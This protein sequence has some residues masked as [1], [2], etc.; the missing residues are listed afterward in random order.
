MILRRLSQSLKTQN[1]TAIWIEFILL[2]V[3][4][5][6]GI[7]V[8]NWNEERSLRAQ[9]RTYLTELSDEVRSNVRQIEYRTAYT[10]ILLESGKTARNFLESDTPCVQDCSSLLADFFIASQF[11]GTPLSQTILVEMQRLGLPRSKAIKSSIQ[12]FYNTTTGMDVTVDSQPR[13]RENVR[14]Y[15]SADLIRGLWTDCWTFEDGSLEIL[16]PDCK[17]RLSNDEA[18]AL[19]EK[20]RRSPDLAKDLDFWLGVN[21]FGLV[22]YP[23]MISTGNDVVAAIDRELS[24]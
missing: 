24:K 8:A 13:Y 4:V 21:E 14:G 19:L 18:S 9:E 2:V 20:I 10:Q 17:A 5:F 23:N 16:R 22:I 3:G 11:W 15:M 6:L 7:Q 1:W 12:I